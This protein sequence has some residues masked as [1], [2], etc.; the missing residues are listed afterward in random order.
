MN[1]KDLA[2]L[3]RRYRPDKSNITR[4]C[5]CF[6]NE[7]KEIISEFDQ[8]LGMMPEEEAEQMLGVL[9][10]V[11]TG[12][13]GRTVLEIDFSTQQVM[14]SEEY[15]LLAEL[16]ATRLKNPDLIKKM[17]ETVISSLELYLSDEMPRA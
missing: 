12:T 6:V 1:E 3:R 11:L 10:K 4:V 2:E 13:V 15:L 9:K 17:Y 14:E 8:S 7:K 16:R 5:G